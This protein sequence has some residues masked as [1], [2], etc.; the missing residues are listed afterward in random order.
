MTTVYA[1]SQAAKG[2]TFGAGHD[3]D[4]GSS[5]F[6]SLGGTLEVQ[7]AAVG[8]GPRHEQIRGSLVPAWRFRLTP[9]CESIKLNSSSTIVR[10]AMLTRGDGHT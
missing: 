9:A 8:A 3:P 4:Q 5:R 7:P 6:V 2:T 10:V 1:T